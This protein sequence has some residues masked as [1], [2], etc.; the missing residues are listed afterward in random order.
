MSQKEVACLAVVALLQGSLPSP[1]QDLCHEDMQ[2]W[3]PLW[4]NTQHLQL[5]LPI[6]NGLNAGDGGLHALDLA[7]AGPA[8]EHI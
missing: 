6:A 1:T 5:L 7:L 4:L 2:V 3:A 8:K